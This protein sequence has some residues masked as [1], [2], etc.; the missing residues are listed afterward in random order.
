MESTLK[1]IGGIAS[2]FVSYKLVVD[3]ILAKSSKHREDYE[4]AKK[5]IDALSNNELHQFVV[6]RGFLALTG[7]S[8][9]VQEIK[10]LLSFD[11]PSKAIK[12]RASSENFIE[13]HMGISEYVWKGKYTYRV[14]RM[15]S[16]YL[17]LV[18]YV[19]AAVLVMLPFYLKG[20]ETFN[21]FVLVVFSLSLGCVAI[22]CLV[23]HEDFRCARKLM[24][25]QKEQID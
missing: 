11:N 21:S 2:L 10:H 17:Y 5:F 14:V 13:L 3:V 12:L 18:G 1:I 23:Q 8:Y 7:K 15:V 16:T 25:M 19:I 20:A 9:S 4:F 24:Q 6:E 22:F